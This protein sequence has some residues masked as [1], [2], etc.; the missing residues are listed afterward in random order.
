MIIYNVSFC[1]ENHLSKTNM[2]VFLMCASLIHRWYFYKVN[3][4]MMTLKILRNMNPEPVFRF[5]FF[6]MSMLSVFLILLWTFFFVFATFSFFLGCSPTSLLLFSFVGV[7]FPVCAMYKECFAGYACTASIFVLCIFVGIDFTEKEICVCFFILYFIVSFFVAEYSVC[8]LCR[9][10][11]LLFIVIKWLLI[12]YLFIISD[13]TMHNS[14]FP[15][16]TPPEI[17]KRVKLRGKENVSH[18]YSYEINS[19]YNLPTKKLFRVITYY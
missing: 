13:E 2:S 10:Y 8:C 17:P 19:K 7:T 11:F 4:N 1:I 3:I 9:F 16:F 12:Q 5:A 6:L 15:T 18:L 14:T